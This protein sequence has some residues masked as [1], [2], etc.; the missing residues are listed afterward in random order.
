[1][2]QVGVLWGA[3]H[4]GPVPAHFR[5]CRWLTFFHLATTDHNITTSAIPS[6]PHY[7]E[8]AALNFRLRAA[9]NRVALTSMQHRGGCEV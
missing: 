5:H 1:V 8:L 2:V 6:V 7:R 4:Y 3:G 9:R